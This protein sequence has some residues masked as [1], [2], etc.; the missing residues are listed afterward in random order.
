MPVSA[1]VRA[2]LRS[3]LHPDDEIHYAFPADVLMS[4]KPTKNMLQSWTLP[5]R[6]SRHRRTS[7]MI[8]C[9]NF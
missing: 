9:R 8:R 1:S 2:R 5:T 7:R 6:R 4:A 3:H